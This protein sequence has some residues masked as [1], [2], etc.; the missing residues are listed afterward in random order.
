MDFPY[1]LNNPTLSNNNGNDNC[2][3]INRIYIYIYYEIMGLFFLQEKFYKGNF[4][5]I[6]LFMKALLGRERINNLILIIAA[7]LLYYC[8]IFFFKPP[9]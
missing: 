9:S 1:D 4:Q 6:A 8:L 5:I 3:F 2:D 7:S